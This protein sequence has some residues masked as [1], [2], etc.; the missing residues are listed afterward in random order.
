MLD[1]SLIYF[2]DCLVLALGCAIEP[3]LVM[4]SEEDAVKKSQTAE[5]RARNISQ[6]FVA[7][8]VEASSLKIHKQKLLFCLEG[9]S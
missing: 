3:Y 9:A 5:T 2:T 4:T 7:L 8:S 6:M 1:C